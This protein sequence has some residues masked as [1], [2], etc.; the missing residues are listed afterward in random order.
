[1]SQNVGA[2]VPICAA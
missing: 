2:E 1:V